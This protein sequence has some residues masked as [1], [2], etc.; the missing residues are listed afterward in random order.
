MDTVSI[1]AAGNVTELKVKIA[2]R[3]SSDQLIWEEEQRGELTILAA[4]LPETSVGIDLREGLARALSELILTEWTKTS[5]GR[6]VKSQY[7]YFTAE[8]RETILA[9]A[10]AEMGAGTAKQAEWDGR[11][12]RRFREYLSET[13]HLL[14]EGFITFRLQDFAEELE[15]G[16]ER[17]V[18]D[19]L[20]DREYK[21]FIRLLKYFVEVQEPKR[22][23][24][25][26]ILNGPGSFEILDDDDQPVDPITWQEFLVETTEGEVNYEDLLISAMITLAPER[27][28]LHL[29]N[30]EARDE[31]VETVRHVFGERA[32]ICTGCARCR[33]RVVGPSNGS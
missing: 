12:Y 5:L 4:S 28:T 2:S 16:V 32:K 13:D 9:Q 1:G 30:E 6:L 18:D 17:A 25:N 26:V 27:L 11:I 3:F 33:H 15:D 31:S 10:Y 29:H 19:F 8:E 21:E 14:L 20:L 22:P 23:H 7:Q 24:L